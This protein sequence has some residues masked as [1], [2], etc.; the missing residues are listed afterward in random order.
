MKKLIAIFFLILGCIIWGIA[1]VPQRTA[2]SYTGPF[3]YGALRFTLGTLVIL[4]VSLCWKREPA[5]NRVGVNG[6]W[7][8]TLLFLGISCQQIGIQYTSA[9]NSGFITGLYLIFVPLQLTIFQKNSPSLTL[10]LGA[11][12]AL[13]GLALLCLQDNLTL[14]RGDIWTLACALILSEYIICVDKYVAKCDPLKLAIVQYSV[15]ALLSFI[16]AGI[17]EREL[18][19]GASSAMFEIFYGGA[20]SVGFA[21]TTQLFAQK[22]I[23]PSESAIIF[24]MEAIFAAWAGWYFLSEALSA[25]QI[26][27]AILMFSAM[28]FACYSQLKKPI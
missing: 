26:V 22:F 9:A 7:L 11:V 24:S 19:H 25:R 13:I 21:Y 16:C 17:F 10:W 12:I 23:P 1:F 28:I 27:G 14:N 4:V 18:M 20:I 15:C 5:I 3:F 6:L 2:M 8:G